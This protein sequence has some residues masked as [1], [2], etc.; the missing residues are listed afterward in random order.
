MQNSFRHDQT[1]NSIATYHYTL[2]SNII[3]LRSLQEFN[4]KS[5]EEPTH[6]Q[7]VEMPQ[8]MRWNCAPSFSILE[9]G[10]VLR[11][12]EIVHNDRPR[13]KIFKFHAKRQRNCTSELQCV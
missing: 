13:L 7:V 4:K 8:K 12:S 11:K 9:D 2:I 10:S 3:S 5:A 1:T 6:K